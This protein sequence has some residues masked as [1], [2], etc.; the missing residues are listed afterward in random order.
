MIWPRG[1][2]KKGERRNKLERVGS[3]IPG[4]RCF[5]SREKLAPAIVTPQLDEN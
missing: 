1:V 2:D 4:N 5:E 3:W